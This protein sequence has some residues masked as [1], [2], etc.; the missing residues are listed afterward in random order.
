MSPLDEIKR[1]DA[2]ACQSD[3]ERDWRWVSP[4]LWAN[5]Y[6]LGQLQQD[7]HA[8]LDML[9]ELKRERASS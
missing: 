2:D 5:T 6:H 1:R 3:L 4:M 8:L 9:D 7:F